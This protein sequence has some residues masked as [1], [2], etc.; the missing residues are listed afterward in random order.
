[1]QRDLH[2]ARESVRFVGQRADRVVPVPRGE[3][4]AVGRA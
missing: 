3:G 4:E 1:M 2:A